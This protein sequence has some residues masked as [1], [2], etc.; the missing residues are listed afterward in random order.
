MPLIENITYQPPF[1]YRYTHFNTIYTALWRPL[2]DLSYERKRIDTPDGDFIDLDWSKVDSDKLLICVHGLEGHAR[3]PYVRGIMHYFNRKHNN[4][5]AKHDLL[6][7]EM[8]CHCEE[9]GRT[10]GWDTVGLNLRSC[11]GEDNRFLYGYHSGKSEDLDFVVESIRA[12][13]KYKQIAIIGFSVGGNIV[14]K[15]GGEKGQNLPPEVTHLMGFSVPCDLTGCS[16]EIEKPKNWIYLNQFLMSLKPKARKKAQLFPGKFDIKKALKSRNFREFDSAYTGPVNG[17]KD[18]F[19]YWEKSSCLP[20]LKNITVPTLLINAKDDTFL[21]PSCFPYEVAQ[22]NPNF[23]LEVSARGGHLGFMSPD[24]EGY[25]WTEHR[26]WDFVHSTSII[27]SQS[28][29]RGQ[30]VKV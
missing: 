12:E 7:Q 3:K 2:L 11:S 16:M 20:L 9:R 24:T 15:Y 28:I 19:D 23:Y 30:I 1:L 18:C 21:S 8:N 22:Q 26:A 27:N 29:A 14:F 5:A 13:K 25:L 4:V 10:E 17:F 6:L